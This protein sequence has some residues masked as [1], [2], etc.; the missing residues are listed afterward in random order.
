MV[1]EHSNVLKQQQRAIT[2]MSAMLMSFT[3]ELA[4]INQAMT[5]HFIHESME[6]IFA[7]KLNLRFIHPHDL[8]QVLQI[9]TKQT[10]INIEEIDDAFPIIELINQLLIQQRIEFIQIKKNDEQ[11]D[12]GVIG[13]LLF[14]SFF[15]AS[16]KN[17][18]PF[19]T[20][21][22]TSIPFNQANQRWKLAQIPHIISISSK[23]LELIQWT[24]KESITCKFKSLS[25]CR[26][27]PP[28]Q[29]NW[30]QTCLFEIL[31]DSNLTFCRIELELEPI[32]IQRIGQQWAIST[33]NETKCH[34]VAQ[35]EEEQHAI[36]TNNEITIPPIA[37]LTIDRST[38]W[39]CDHFL[40]PGISNDTNELIHIIDNKK[41]NYDDSKLINLYQTM[42]NNTQW[43]KIPYIP[44]NIKNMIEYVIATTPIP[45]PTA[46]AWYQHGLAVT[47]GLLGIIATTSIT[48]YFKLIGKVKKTSTADIITMPSM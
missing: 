25:S 34:R 15:A 32:F 8:P 45:T 30:Q 37:L 1:N 35:L 18:Q 21:K 19:S 4:S 36:T 16:N 31:T 29:K 44:E 9:I 12:G 42:N 43:K 38:T 13:N 3:K 10:N 41:L 5:M 27:T 26:E 22:L 33:R 48:L 2:T 20:Y 23:T 47:V 14:T 17:Q 40:L 46:T 7:N 39:S 28:I 24:K 6:D 11:I